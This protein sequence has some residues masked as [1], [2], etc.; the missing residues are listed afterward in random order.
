M[1]ESISTIRLYSMTSYPYLFMVLK[2][3][4]FELFL[5]LFNEEIEHRVG[6][7]FLQVA[8]LVGKQKGRG[9]KKE[10]D[11]TVNIDSISSLTAAAAVTK[12]KSPP[13]AL[14]STTTAHLAVVFI[15]KDLNVNNA[16]PF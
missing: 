11:R 14:S 16:R 8:H 10:N 4:Q 5:V 12:L 7:S 3:K 1:N 15:L 9:R 13:P 6:V 2:F